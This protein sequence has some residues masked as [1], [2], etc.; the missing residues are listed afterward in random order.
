[1]SKHI[2]DNQTTDIEEAI[3]NAA[4]Q[5]VGYI[6]VSSVDQNTERQLE[7]IKLDKVFTD[8]ISGSKKDRPALNQLINYVREG[9]TVL[10]HSMDRLARDLETLIQIVKGLNAKGVSIRFV[11]ENITFTARNNNSMDKLLL[12]ILGAVAEFKRSLIREAQQEG[13]AIAKRKGKYKGRKPALTAEQLAQLRI[14][15]EKMKPSELAKK[16]EVHYQTIWRYLKK[17][18]D[19]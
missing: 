2:Y 15:K 1:M 12:H 13:I 14:D 7:G 11:K 3:N 10:V 18:K 4:T 8:K 6:R 17:M 5:T 16:Y 9:D 19:P